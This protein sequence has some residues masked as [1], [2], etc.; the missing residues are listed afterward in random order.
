MPDLSSQVEGAQAVP[1]AMSP[2]LS[3]MPRIRAM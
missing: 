2:L 3:P 1:F